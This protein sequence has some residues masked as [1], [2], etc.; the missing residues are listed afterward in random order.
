[1]KKEASEKE[2]YKEEWQGSMENKKR[3]ESITVN[4]QEMQ[5]LILMF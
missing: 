3:G 2:Y 1:M 4:A 5:T